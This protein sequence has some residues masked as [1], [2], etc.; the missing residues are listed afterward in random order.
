MKGSSVVKQVSGAHVSE[1]N[2]SVKKVDYK[3]D[4]ASGFQVILG[5]SDI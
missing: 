4:Q 1:T 5:T 2:C 3:A